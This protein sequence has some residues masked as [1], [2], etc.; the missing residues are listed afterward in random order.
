MW[1]ALRHLSLR[2]WRQVAQKAEEPKDGG[3]ILFAGICRRNR[4]L[5]AWPQVGSEV[6]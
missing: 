1:R 6:K 4:I 2:Q 3:A 5:A